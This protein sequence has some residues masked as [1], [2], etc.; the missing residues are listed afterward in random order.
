MRFD[1]ERSWAD[2]TNL[3]KARTL[4]WPIKKRFGKGLSWGDLFALTGDMS[5]QE[6]G[7]PVLGFC[8]G[9]FDDVNGAASELLGPT[10]EQ[11][12]LFPCKPGDGLCEGPLGQ[13]TLGLI[14]VNPEGPLGVP[15]PVA[16][17]SE[18]RSTFARMGMNDSETVALIGG[19]HT[20]GKTHGSCPK[21]AGPGPD[22]DPA[23]PWP[24]LCGTGKG[25]DAFT[26]GF[27]GPWVSTPTVWQN[28][29]FYNLLDFEWRKKIGPGGHWQWYPWKGNLVAPAAF[30]KGTQGS[31]CVGVDFS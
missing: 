31:L 21:G 26:S 11:K 20:L 22:E 14:Y 1:P 7:G 30:G 3:D 28:E 17:I 25:Q 10:A 4:L 16:S 19:G 15:D 6:S 23:N 29:Y 8:A 18:T 12:E 5:I 9:R 13:N 2:D 24:G 27:E